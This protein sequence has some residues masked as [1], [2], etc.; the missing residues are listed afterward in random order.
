MSFH[1]LEPLEVVI[2]CSCWKNEVKVI[3]IFAICAVEKRNGCFHILWVCN[4]IYIS[5]DFHAIVEFSLSFGKMT[6][7]RHFLP[8]NI[9][10]HSRITSSRQIVLAHLKCFSNSKFKK[11]RKYMSRWL[12]CVK[13]EDLDDSFQT[14]IWNLTRLSFLVLSSLLS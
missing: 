1:Q 14:L 13:I 11:N 9:W 8:L 6:I 3:S 12:K 7:P 10:Y 5:L 2:S 4:C